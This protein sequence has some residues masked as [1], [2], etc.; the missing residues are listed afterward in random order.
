MNKQQQWQINLLAAECHSLSHVLAASA[1]ALLAS[2]SIPFGLKHFSCR[3]INIIIVVVITSHSTH[4]QTCSSSSCGCYC[5][6]C[7]KTIPDAYVVIEESG[8]RSTV[9]AFKTRFVLAKAR[10]NSNELHPMRKKKTRNNEQRTWRKKKKKTCESVEN[11]QS[12]QHTQK[13]RIMRK[14]E[15]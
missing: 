14:D 1:A 9:I 8:W 2:N 4:T 13:E 5:C 3:V 11:V 12:L 6:Y 15:K 7:K 10:T